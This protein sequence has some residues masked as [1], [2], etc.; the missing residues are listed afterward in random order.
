[1]LWD[2]MTGLGDFS[3]KWAEAEAAVAAADAEFVALEKEFGVT[4]ASFYEDADE[5]DDL[6]LEV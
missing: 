2:Y 4:L 1:M 6:D 5:N 3:P